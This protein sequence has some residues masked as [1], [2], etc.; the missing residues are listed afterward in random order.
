MNDSSVQ[1]T[2]SL[3]LSFVA[4]VLLLFITVSGGHN[5]ALYYQSNGSVNGISTENSEARARKEKEY[6]EYKLQ[7]ERRMKMESMGTTETVVQN[8]LQ[9]SC[10][11]CMAAGQKFLC[12]ERNAKLAKCMTGLPQT[13]NGNITCV[14]CGGDNGTPV[15][16]RTPEPTKTLPTPPPGCRYEIMV[17]TSGNCQPQYR[18]VCEN[19]TPTPV[20]V[21]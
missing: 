12:M 17:C 15:I 20:A 9:L 3:A 10:R 2:K 5:N 14:S 1:F 4:L 16:T 11:E 18:L 21:Q 13:N 8:K 7:S 6:K 19:P